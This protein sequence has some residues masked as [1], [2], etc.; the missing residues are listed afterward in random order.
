MGLVKVS[1]GGSQNRPVRELLL[2]DPC[3][4]RVKT[5]QPAIQFGS[6]ADLSAKQRDEPSWTETRVP[7]HVR[8]RSIMGYRLK[9]LERIRDGRMAPLWSV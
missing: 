4:G 7:G 6:Q 8:D 9:L 3:E 2:S 1:T 5:P